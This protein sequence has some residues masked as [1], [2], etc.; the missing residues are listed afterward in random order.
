MYSLKV[1]QE[2]RH[3]IRLYSYQCLTEQKIVQL[4]QYE[5]KGHEK[6]KQYFVIFEFQKQFHYFG[7]IKEFRC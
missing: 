2:F 3:V 4:F 1:F 6:I 7:M 5:I